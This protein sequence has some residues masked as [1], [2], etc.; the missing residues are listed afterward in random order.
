MASPP[1]L[2]LL[3]FFLLFSSASSITLS[4][5]IFESQIFPGRSLLQQKPSCGIDFQNQNYTVIT[6]QCKGPTFQAKACCGALKELACPF[7]DQLND[8]KND[9][10]ATLFSYINLHGKYPPGLFANLC[11][12]GKEG[13]NCDEV[14]EAKA[15]QQKSSS[16]VAAQKQLNFQC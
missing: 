1:F 4:N 10:A 8:M 3:L 12:D 9:C 15:E 2:H 6:S 7:S 14:L 16:A 13:L 11:H 5:D